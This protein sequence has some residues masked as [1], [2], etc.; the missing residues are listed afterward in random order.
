MKIFEIILDQVSN[1][2][3]FEMAFDRKEAIKKFQNLDYQI[4]RHLIKITAFK[5]GLNY[6]HHCGEINGWLDHLNDVKWNR[7]QHLS[8][9]CNS[10]NRRLILYSSIR[11]KTMTMTCVS[12][13]DFSIA[14]STF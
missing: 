13:F 8:I 10:C 3:L 2:A 6:Q 14:L 5:D 12:V 7:T 4:Q 11:K 1:T 9:G